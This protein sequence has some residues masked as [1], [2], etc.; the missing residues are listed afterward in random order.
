M[1]LLSQLSATC[2][3]GTCCYLIVVLEN[4]VLL[5]KKKKTV[6]P[7]IIYVHTEY[8]RQTAS[9]LVCQLL[10]LQSDNCKMMSYLLVTVSRSG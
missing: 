3:C 2:V 10:L 7:R 6:F 9:F 4:N 8:T 5:P 1:E